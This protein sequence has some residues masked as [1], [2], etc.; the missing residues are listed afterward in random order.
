MSR[1]H[2]VAGALHLGACIT[3]RDTDGSKI[4]TLVVSI[5]EKS[6]EGFLRERTTD[7]LGG[8]LIQAVFTAEDSITLIT[9][10]QGNAATSSN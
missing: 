10:S 3:L 4:E 7:P 9:L 1:E 5:V 6:H 2:P 8:L